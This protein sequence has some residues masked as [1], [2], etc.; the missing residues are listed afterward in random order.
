MKVPSNLASL[1][2]DDPAR[3]ADLCDALR[4]AGTF[5]FDTEFIRERSYKPVV[6]LVQ[7]AT[8][9]RIALID[10]L[11]LDLLPFWDLVVDPSIE[12]VVHSGQQDLEMCHL[13]TGRL[14]AN[15]FDVQVAAGFVGPAYPLSYDKIVRE[16]LA[17]HIEK[18]ET[19]SEWAQRPLTASQLRYAVEDVLYLLPIKSRLERRLQ[20]KGRLMWLREE[21]QR[22]ESADLYACEAAESF[23]KVRGA[24]SLHRQNMAVLR[25]LAIWR[26]RAAEVRDVPT[27]TLLKDPV[28]VGIARRMPRNVKELAD[29]RGMPDPVVR[30]SGMDILD[31]VRRG[32]AVPEDQCPPAEER[33]DERPQDRMVADLASVVG[34]ALCMEAN[35]AHSL[36]ATRE[37]YLELALAV[38][39][40]RR[41]AD[42]PPPRLLTGWRREFAGDRLTSALKGQASLRMKGLPRTPHLELE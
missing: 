29:L 4:R 15:V 33:T 9:D 22:L 19:F 11:E 5:A 8:A 6:C 39:G 20:E 34:Q 18:G 26:E 24:G 41:P 35:L 2:I 32:R 36:F 27:R 40:R 14:P 30:R 3:L 31:A 10:P 7:V 42:A 21:M 38:C 13:A 37:H 28:L 25:E 16:V 12:T 17:I 1:I 23:L